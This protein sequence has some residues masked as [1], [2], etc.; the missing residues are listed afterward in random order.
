MN[1]KELSAHLGLSPTTVS[2]ALNGYSDVSAST[3]QRVTEAAQKLGYQPDGA[4]RRLARGKADAVGIVFPT[5]S[6]ELGDPR[7][8][9]V[10]AGLTERFETEGIDLLITSAAP[11]REHE[12]FER[13]LRLRRVDGFIVPHTRVDDARIKFLLQAQAPFVAY[14]RTTGCQSYPWF[15]FDNEAG[16]RLA[17]QRL[18]SRGHTDIAYVHAPQDLTFSSQRRQGFLDAMAQ[19]SLPVAPDRLIETP[20]NRRGGYQAMQT[21]LQQQ[22]RPTAVIVDNNL[23]GVGVIRCLLD[24]GMTPGRDMAVI[25]YDGEP[26]DAMLGPLDITA[27]VQPEPHAAGRRMAEL[28]LEALAG[29]PFDELQVL[30]Q[31]RLQPGESDGPPPSGLAAQAKQNWVPRQGLK[32]GRKA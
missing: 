13:L 14:G 3:R 24:A 15:D 12:T 11:S 8:L 27:I 21:L 22:H 7:F 5:G 4:A 6:G 29:K 16:T 30:W 31:P 26:A 17:V 9:E 23:S 10:V 25:L 19:A 18:L 32:D 28:M 20:F 2:R 1:L